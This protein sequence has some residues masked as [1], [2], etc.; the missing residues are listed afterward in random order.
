MRFL[1]L[2]LL[3]LFVAIQVLSFGIW[4]QVQAWQPAFLEP[5]I[6]RNPIISHTAAQQEQEFSHLRF[7]AR[8]LNE[9]NGQATIPFENQII[10]VLR[11]LPRGHA[12]AIHHV[13]LDYS[14][15]IRRGLGGSKIV[16]L[17]AVKMDDEEFVGVLIHEIGHNVDLVHLSPKNKKQKSVFK[18]GSTPIY[19]TDPSLDFY[20]ISWQNEKTMK[21]T[22]DNMDFV[23]GYAMSDTFEDFA[24][25]YIYYILHNKN[26]KALTASNDALYAKYKFM[27]KQ[28]FNGIEF[29]T[30]DGEASLNKR[31][32]DTTVL[33]Y[34]L[35]GFLN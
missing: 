16:I 22:A 10:N 5:I 33:P 11:K 3:I 13:I 12:E 7:S 32:W 18:D 14:P 20:Q 2:K 1:Y 31:H 9:T 27:K 30:G 6:T 4:H 15:S 19:L 8:N 34:D 29:D 35:E 17:R 28:V 21:K 26:F 25:T 23:S 24:E